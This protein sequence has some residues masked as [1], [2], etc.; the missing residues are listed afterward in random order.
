[1]N[2]DNS[3]IEDFSDLLGDRNAKQDVIVI[4]RKSDANHKIL[5]SL[6]WQD[7]RSIPHPAGNLI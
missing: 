2:I 6:F 4:V 1:M 7:L 5:K 3:S